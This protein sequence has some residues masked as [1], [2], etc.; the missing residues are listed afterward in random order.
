MKEIKAI[1]Q[2]FMLSK[3]VNALKEIPDMPGVTVSEVKGFGRGRAENVAES[4]DSMTEW[5]VTFVLKVKLEVV[6][7]DT[8]VDQVIETIQKH[9]HTGNIGDGKIFVYDVNHI[10]KIRTNESDEMAL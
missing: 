1:I 2:P 8:M 5:G 7:A 9:A 3:V 6:I 4:S 10:I